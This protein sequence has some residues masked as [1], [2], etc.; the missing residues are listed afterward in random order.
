[1]KCV[2]LHIVFMCSSNKLTWFAYTGSWYVPFSFSL[3]WFTWTFAAAFSTLLSTKRINKYIYVYPDF[4]FYLNTF[5]ETNI[6][7][8]N[9]YNCTSY[10]LRL[11]LFSCT[12][13]VV[14]SG[15]PDHMNVAQNHKFRVNLTCQIPSA[16]VA[17]CVLFPVTPY[18]IVIT[19][20][21]IMFCNKA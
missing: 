4:K 2:F 15:K 20:D 7:K 8:Y 17:E 16:S 1:M 3:S 10:Q 18:L 21:Y 13:Y 6:L 12:I 5:N 14:H 11:C 9:W 19:E